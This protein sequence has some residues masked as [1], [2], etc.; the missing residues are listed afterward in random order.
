MNAA[1]PAS[2]AA[3]VRASH[4]LAEYHE[5]YVNCVQAAQASG[6]GNR[7]QLLWRQND[8]IEGAETAVLGRASVV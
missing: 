8:P 5:T 4:I 2:S 6:A 7:S 3:I 1:N